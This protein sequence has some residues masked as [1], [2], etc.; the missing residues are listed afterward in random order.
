MGNFSH[1]SPAARLKPG[2]SATEGRAVSLPWSS[3]RYTAKPMHPSSFC[4]K[5]HATVIT[6]LL[7]KAM[8]FC[9]ADPPL[10]AYS[11]RLSSAFQAQVEKLSQ[12]VAEHVV[13]QQWTA[14]EA[15]L[16]T[17]TG[18]DPAPGACASS[19]LRREGK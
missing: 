4:P 5:L 18:G 8:A 10:G 11:R 9:M 17:G 12:R 2:E 7:A 1:V 13:L 16:P 19:R 6:S 3:M 14:P 15:M